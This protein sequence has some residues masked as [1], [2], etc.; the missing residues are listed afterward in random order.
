MEK[1]LT[2]KDS[3]FFALAQVSSRIEQFNRNCERE[4][5]ISL[6]QWCLLRRLMD[7]PG[8]SAQ[9]LAKMVGVHPS[10]LTQSLKRLEK[11]ALI[12]ITPDAHDSR[13]KVISITRKGKEALEANQKLKLFWE[14]EFVTLKQ[15]LSSFVEKIC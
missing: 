10:T 6:S 11:K 9:A 1:Q 13:R 3:N 8:T 4:L 5:G 14:S 7:A 12:V 15:E 2:F